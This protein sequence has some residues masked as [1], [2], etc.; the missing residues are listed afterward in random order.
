MSRDK[1]KEMIKQKGGSVSNAVSSR[2]T[3]VVA[4]ADSGSKHKKA[5]ELSVRILNEEDFLKMIK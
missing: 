1:A 4:G 2:T 5:E 3:F